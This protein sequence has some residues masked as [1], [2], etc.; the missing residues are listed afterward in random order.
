M[1]VLFVSVEF[2]IS[3]IFLQNLLILFSL[4]SVF[5]KKGTQDKVFC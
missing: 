4:N 3:L 1:N 5:V 2:V